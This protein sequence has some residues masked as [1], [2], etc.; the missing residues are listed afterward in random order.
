VKL[1]VGVLIAAIGAAFAVSGAYRMLRPRRAEDVEW[2]RSNPMSNWM[3]GGLLLGFDRIG[4]VIFFVVG[5]FAV[6]LGILLLSA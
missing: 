5:G 6:A 3:L 2:I 1:A 4:A